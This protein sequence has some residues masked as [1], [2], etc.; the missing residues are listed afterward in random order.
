MMKYFYSLIVAI[1][2]PFFAVAQQTIT[3]SVNPPSFDETDAISV[4]FTVNETAFGVGSSHALYL[5]AWS[6]DS[7]NV[8]MDAP[9]NGTWTASNAANKLTYVSSSAGM[10]TYTFTMNTVKSF[11]GNRPNPL[12]K[13]GFLVKTLNG[14]VQSQDIMLNVG[15]FQFNLTNPLAGSTNIVSSGT[16][17]NITGTASMPANYVIKANGTPVYSSS[18]AS[19]SL[20]YGYTVT[21]DATIDV[22]ATNAADGTVVTK[23]FTVSLSIPVD[24]APMP[25]YMRQGINYDP[26]DPTKVG[27]AL[28]APGKPYVHV[29]GSFNNWTV[30]GNYLMK[31]DTTNT[32][33]YWIEVSG[34]TPQ[35]IYTFQYRI[36]DGTRVADPYST[37]VLSPYDDQW[38]NQNATVYP[39][40]PP[41]PAGQDFEV[42]VVQTQK[43]AY[44]WVV[45]NFAKPAKENLIV[46]ELL[47]RDFTAQQTWQS[48]I[49]KIAYLKTLNINAVELMPVMEFDG[50]N[51]WGYNTGF[52]NAL[53]KAYG[54]PEKF[55]E[56]I[57]VCHQNGIA[58]I[59]DIA[60]NHAT[61]RS[62]LVRMWMND[63]D[64]DGYGDPSASNPYFNQVATHSYGVFNDFNHSKAETKYYVNRVLEQWIK[65]Y[66]VDGFRWDLTK[67]FTQNCTAGDDACTNNYQQDRVNILKAYADYQWSWDPTSYIIFEHLGTD[68][69]EAQWANYKI[70]EGKGVMMWD[71]QTNPYNQNTMGYATGSNFN[72]VKY[73]AHGF[74]ERRALSYGESHDEERIMYKNL[75][76]GAAGANTL[77]AALERQKSYGAVFLT[78]PGPKMIWQFAELGFDKSIFTCVNGT[79]NTDSDSIPGDC[80]L[81]PKPSAFGLGY[82]VDTARKSVYDTWAKI[83]AIRL[84]N[85]VF[86]TKN[87]TVESGNLMPRIYITNTA[88]A[89][90]LQNVVILANFTTST[91]NIVPNFPIGNKTWF[92]LMDNTSFFVSDTTAPITI[93]AGGF[94]I[95]GDGSALATEETETVKNAVS[96]TVLQNPVTNGVANI[97]YSNADNGTLAIYDLGGKLVKSQKVS[98]SKG[99]ET[100]SVNGLSSGIYLIQL[101]SDKGMAVAKMI[102]K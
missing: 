60:L 81:D 67:G 15:R 35:Q 71:K 79:V 95:F 17:V 12:S 14:S 23:S 74:S 77:A 5:W 49:D 64:G 102:V 57:D 82:D 37:L 66:K 43:P 54:T 59:L 16:V 70:G 53:D 93:E 44:P 63:P 34:L 58:V 25:A 98:K 13:I 86:N 90:A 50:N 45:T 2:L 21:Q 8:S 100:I 1:I 80:K 83:L 91:Q 19:T 55:K 40:L 36:A 56:F 46:Y 33:L 88:A 28:Y 68:S 41:Y 31:R 10:G 76:F 78:V 85:E 20:S 29:I 32:N 47:V 24:S 6:F 52:H 51:S 30:S 65:E 94:R 62:P 11:Y 89:S 101:K 73:T 4:T 92:N 26:N 96:L 9:T 75:N 22:V 39:N 48:L 7:N 18:A 38:I 87:F 84:S 99:D 3:Y 72:R 97:R 61:G 69:E 42:S 27:L